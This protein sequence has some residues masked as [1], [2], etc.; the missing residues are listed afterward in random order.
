MNAR[1]KTEIVKAELEYGKYW[2]RAI[3]RDSKKSYPKWT[4]SKRFVLLIENAAKNI[5]KQNLHYCQ[6]KSTHLVFAVNWAGKSQRT[7]V[8]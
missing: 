2:F 6:Q 4:R 5:P 7:L 3:K 1:F 8:R